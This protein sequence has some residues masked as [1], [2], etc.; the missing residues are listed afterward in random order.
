M[1]SLIAGQA[2]KLVLSA[3]DLRPQ[4][5][6]GV[7]LRDVLDKWTVVWHE[8]A[9][10]VDGFRVPDLAVFEVVALWVEG[11]QESE[12]GADAEVRDDDVERLVEELVFADLRHEVVPDRLLGRYCALN[13]RSLHRGVSRY[14][15]GIHSVTRWIVHQ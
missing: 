8:V 3:L 6:L 7:A 9:G 11:G 10:D 4:V 12:L 5:V 15:H 14:L 2:G 1:G 13:A